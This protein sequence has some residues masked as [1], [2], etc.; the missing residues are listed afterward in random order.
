MTDTANA[1]ANAVRK[2]AETAG[3]FLLAKGVS[4]F[5]EAR[6]SRVYVDGSDIGKLIEAA[7]PKVVYLFEDSF[8]LDSELEAAQETLTELGVIQLPA[9][10]KAQKRQLA[11]HSG[12]VCAAIATVMVD[13]ILHSAIVTDDWYDEFNDLVE[14]LTAEAREDEAGIR[15]AQRKAA[16][17]EIAKKAAELAAHP[18]FNFSRVSFEKRLILAEAIFEDCD[19]QTLSEITRQAENIFW[20]EQSG[21]KRKA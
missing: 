1:L 20:L 5:D 3:S 2:A 13:G 12:Q 18:S 8:D 21:F 7:R 16:S 17:A 9:K 4:N 15:L 11:A 6:V 10:L 19:H 14:A